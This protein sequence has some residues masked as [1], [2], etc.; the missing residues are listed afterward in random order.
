VHVQG[1]LN[2]T[3]D[4]DKG[5][6]VEIAFP[7]AGMNHLAGGRT[8]PPNNGDTWR[9]FFGRFGKLRLGNTIIGNAMSWNLI[10]DNDNHMPERF[11]QVS[12]STQ[13]APMK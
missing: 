12:F 6:T 10:G 3:S 11:T 8:L 13:A 7:W 4:I 2:D 1:T 5:W 9:I